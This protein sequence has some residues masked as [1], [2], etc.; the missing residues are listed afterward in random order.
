MIFSCD[1]EEI[2]QTGTGHGGGGLDRF[3]WA[4]L[5]W[6]SHMRNRRTVWTHPANQLLQYS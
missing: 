4:L 5:D 1:P 6:G 2:K 3:A